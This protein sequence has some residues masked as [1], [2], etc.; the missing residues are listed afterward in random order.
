[1]LGRSTTVAEADR[2]KYLLKVL[3][4][5]AELGEVTGPFA[6]TQGDSG[7]PYYAN[8]GGT[9]TPV[10]LGVVSGGDGHCVHKLPSIFTHVGSYVPWIN[11]YTSGMDQ[12]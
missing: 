7:G 3:L 2:R 10:L 8:R 11:F 12:G 6:R 4:K 5:S 9:Q 1:M